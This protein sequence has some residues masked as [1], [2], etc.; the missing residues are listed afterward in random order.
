MEELTSE[1]FRTSFR[2][3]I[4]VYISFLISAIDLLVCIVVIVFKLKGC[5]RRKEGKSTIRAIGL[6]V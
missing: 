5:L 2:V 3:V 6:V 4:C 1:A